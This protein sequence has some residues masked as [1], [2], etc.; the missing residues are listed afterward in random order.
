MKFLITEEEK[1]L[2]RGM[3]N[4]LNEDFLSSL[5]HD[6]H[7]F[8]IQDGKMYID[9]F[10]YDT[11]FEF[12]S[13]IKKPNPKLEFMGMTNLGGQFLGTNFVCSIYIGNETDHKNLNLNNLEMDRIAKA[14]SEKQPVITFISDVKSGKYKFNIKLKKTNKK[15]KIE[16]E[17]PKPKPSQPNPPKTPKPVTEPSTPKPVTEP[18][19][20][21]KP[22]IEIKCEENFTEIIEK[23]KKIN[24]ITLVT[25]KSFKDTDGLCKIALDIEIDIDEKERF[26]CKIT[27]DMI[28][29]CK[30]YSPEYQKIADTIKITL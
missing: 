8:E 7:E 5:D 16:S 29:D 26:F 20:F 2:I 23:V 1:N 9:G 22:V 11:I 30:S 24:D 19:Q 21:T 12:T 28:Y 27:K 13:K 18:P 17:T 15:K 6:G 10:E 14:I 3:Y 4:L 25:G